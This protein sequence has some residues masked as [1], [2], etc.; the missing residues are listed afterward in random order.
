[1]AFLA[2]LPALHWRSSIT[3]IVLALLEGILRLLL[4]LLVVSIL[5]F[6]SDSDVPCAAVSD[7][8]LVACSGEVPLGQDFLS[9]V[10][11]DLLRE[12]DDSVELNILL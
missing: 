7:Y 10:R 1:M 6:M 2:A 11:T 8:I 5:L 9:E 12:L 3:V 4:G